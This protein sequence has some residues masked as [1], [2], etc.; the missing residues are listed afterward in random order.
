MF[1]KPDGGH[2]AMCWM[3]QLFGRVPRTV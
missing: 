2:K 3:L 1:L